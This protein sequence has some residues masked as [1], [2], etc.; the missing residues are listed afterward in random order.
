[1]QVTKSNVLV[2]KGSINSLES[3]HGA[4]T[5]V[6]VEAINTVMEDMLDAKDLKAEYERR[7]EQDLESGGDGT[8]VE[9]PRRF[10]LDKDALALLKQA[11]G[12]LKEN[13][14][15]MDI[16]KKSSERV[17]RND[18]NKLLADKRNEY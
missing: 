5:K 11:Q 4:V 1:M 15:Q 7:L 2:G 17:L 8:E 9:K 18:I 14:V 6:Y 12:F 13:D 16:T 10:I 3:L